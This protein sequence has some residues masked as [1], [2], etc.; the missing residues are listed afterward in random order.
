[1]RAETDTNRK[2]DDTKC[3]ISGVEVGYERK[4]DTKCKSGARWQVWHQWFNGVE[5]GLRPATPHA[6]TPD[7]R[8]RARTHTHVHHTIPGWV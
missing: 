5:V 4:D 8:T 3:G 6:H 1:L 7:A 2:L